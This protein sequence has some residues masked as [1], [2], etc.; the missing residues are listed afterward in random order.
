MFRR[1]FI[2]CGLMLASARRAWAQLASATPKYHPLNKPVRISLDKVSTPWSPAP[3]TAEATAPTSKGGRRVLISG[4]PFR[5]TAKENR[6]ELSALCLTCPHEQCQV[7]LITDTARLA[8][9]KSAPGHPVFQCGCHASVFDALEDGVA[10]DGPT[11][12]GLYR[13]RVNIAADGAAEIDQVEEDA[14][15]EV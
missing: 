8:T 4:G 1:T 13:F 6:P 11:P 3:F 5:R 14:L 7:D 9:I 12:R 2:V 15:S 10:L